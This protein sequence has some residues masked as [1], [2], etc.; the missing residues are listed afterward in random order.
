[1]L[2]LATLQGTTT[3]G[4]PLNPIARWEWVFPIIESI[5]ICGFTLLVGSVVILG[6]PGVV[7][8]RAHGS[9]VGAC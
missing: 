5:H 4:L 1:M 2:L 6:R 3:E 7:R 9:N 8:C